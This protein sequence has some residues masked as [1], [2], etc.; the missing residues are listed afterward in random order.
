M[1]DASLQV[2]DPELS[3]NTSTTSNEP[4]HPRGTSYSNYN[5]NMILA[6]RPAAKT[7]C[8]GDTLSRLS[9]GSFDIAR[10]RHFPTPCFPELYDNKDLAMEPS[11]LPLCSCEVPSQSLDTLFKKRSILEQIR[12]V[13]STVNVESARS[14]FLLRLPQISFLAAIRKYRFN[15]TAFAPTSSH[16]HQR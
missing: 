1:P 5:G 12:L 7:K 4:D 14:A 16:K 8:Q 15:L 6:N 11:Q 9:L 13:M 10:R 2:A 3:A